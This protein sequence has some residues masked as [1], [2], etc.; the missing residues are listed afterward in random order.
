MA[1]GD[2]TVPLVIGICIGVVATLCTLAAITHN[3]Y[4]KQGQIDCL[5]G[6]IYYRLEKQMNG[7]TDWV[8]SKSIVK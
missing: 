4:H 2:V 1:N 6:A 3:D 8:Y 5:N 7:T